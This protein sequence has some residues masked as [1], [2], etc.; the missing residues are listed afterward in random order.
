MLNVTLTSNLEIFFQRK[1]DVVIL[2]ILDW[3]QLIYICHHTFAKSI[4][5]R[6][7]PAILIFMTM[8]V[9]RHNVL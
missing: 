8:P 7:S 4:V 9:A 2:S 6:T 5:E 1:G 3:K